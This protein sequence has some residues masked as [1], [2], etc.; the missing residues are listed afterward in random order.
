M[1]LT[2]IQKSNLESD[3]MILR[4]RLEAEGIVCYLKN[5]FTTQLMSYVPTCE[6]E[7]QV[8]Y[9]DLERVEKIMRDMQ[10]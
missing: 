1:S 9:S 7:L 5:Q 6:V 3:L 4:G 10:V 8:S 2:T